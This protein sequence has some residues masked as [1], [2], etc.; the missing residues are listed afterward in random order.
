MAWY[1]VRIAKFVFSIDIPRNTE[2]D[3]FYWPDE[4]LRADDGAALKIKEYL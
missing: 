3:Y 4:A 1:V 2:N